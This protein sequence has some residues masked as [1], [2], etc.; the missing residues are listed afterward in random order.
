MAAVYGALSISG[1]STRDQKVVVFGAGTAGMGVAD[2]IRDAMVA[3]GATVE[4]ATSQIWPIASRGLLFDDMDRLRDFQI[5][6]AKNRRQLGV[7]DGIRVGLVDAIK[8]ASPTM[9]LGCSTMY[10][11][12]TREVIEAM[13]ASTERP[14]IF[15]ISNPTS[16]MEARPADVLQWSDGKALVA[17]GSPVPPVRYDGI[18]YTIAQANNA[19]VFPGIGLGVIVAGAQRVTKN[20]LGAAAKAVARQADPTSPGAELL[21]DVT[22]L[23]A[24]SAEVAE[25]VYHGAVEGGVA[26]KKHDNI[27]QAILDAMWLPEYIEDI[28]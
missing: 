9:L 24:V 2:Q 28:A 13:V 7:P 6:Y 8:M 21:P 5:P 4:Q 18:T 25:A 22:N 1:L 27:V 15:P 26:T 3:D 10:G 14:L 23:R 11:A 20:M 12:F 17:T 16:R 19:L